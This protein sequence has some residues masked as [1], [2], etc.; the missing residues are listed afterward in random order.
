MGRISESME[1]QSFQ[2]KEKDLEL[3][4]QYFNQTAITLKKFELVSKIIPDGFL[5]R[6]VDK[7]SLDKS[8]LTGRQ[9]GILVGAIAAVLLLTAKY[10]LPAYVMFC[11]L[12]MTGNAVRSTLIQRSLRAHKAVLDNL[13]AIEERIARQVDAEMEKQQN[14]LGQSYEKTKQMYEGKIGAL[15]QKVGQAVS[16]ASSS[17]QFT[18]D[19]GKLQIFEAQLQSLEDRE[20]QRGKAE[21]AVGAELE[22]LKGKLAEAEKL[23]ETA[24]GTLQREYLNSGGTEKS[25]LYNPNFLVDVA[26]GKPAMH[27]HN[28]GSNLYLYEDTM[29]YV[30]ASV[31]DKPVCIEPD[32]L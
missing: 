1:Q 23:L 32:L 20:A 19:A 4:V 22:G 13:S 16:E 21:Q 8:K 7:L 9:F 27:K 10:T 17:F 14:E 6:Q 3:Y 28:R 5:S 26:D 25:F 29:D 24:V 31:Q 11:A 12:L 15:K 18:E 30:P 2:I